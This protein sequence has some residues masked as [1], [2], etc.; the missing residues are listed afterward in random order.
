MYLNFVL[1]M[2]VY[3]YIILAIKPIAICF[4]LLYMARYFVTC[5]NI[6][7]YASKPNT[8]IFFFFF[9]ECIILIRT[10]NESWLFHMEAVEDKFFTPRG[11][12]SLVTPTTSTLPWILGESILTQKS[13]YSQKWCW[14][15]WSKTHG[16]IISSSS[17]VR[18]HATTSHFWLMIQ[19]HE[20]H[21]GNFGSR[22]LESQKV[23]SIKL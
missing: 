20:S 19:A 6:V 22:G 15:P 3:I 7:K 1:Y 11:L 18:A 17:I 23:C 13:P 12:I 9:G 5:Y 2:Y 14:S 16:D 4:Q 8:I 10:W 21:R